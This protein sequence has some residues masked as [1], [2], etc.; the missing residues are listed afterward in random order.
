MLVLL[1]FGRTLNAADCT[2]SSTESCQITT[3]STITFA[4]PISQIRSESFAVYVD[5]AADGS[6]LN[7]EDLV[8]ANT[9]GIG[10][11]LRSDSN[12]ITLDNISDSGN[13][14][15]TIGLQLEAST[16]N[17]ITVD[18]NIAVIKS[19]SNE[20]FFNNGSNNNTFSMTGNLSNAESGSPGNNGTSIQFT[21]SDE[22]VFTLVG[23][24]IN[25]GNSS[26]ALSLENSDKNVFTITSSTLT[27]SGSSLPMFHIKAGSLNN[28]LTLHANLESSGDTARNFLIEGASNH[29]T[30][31]VNGSLT[32][33][34]D[35]GSNN[36]GING[37][38]NNR[39]TLNGA[40]SAT[41]DGSANINLVSAHSNVF[42]VTGALSTTGLD[43]VILTD[44][45]SNTLSLTGALTSSGVNSH[46]LD[47]TTS[48][49]NTLTV[50]GDLSA[51]NTGAA[52]IYLNGG[53]SNNITVTGDLVSSGASAYGL[54]FDNVNSSGIS[55]GQSINAGSSNLI[56]VRGTITTAAATSNAIHFINS[57]NNQLSLK[58]NIT[59]GAN[60]IYFDATS[61]NNT[62]DFGVDNVVLGT[63]YNDGS[64]NQLNFYYGASKSYMFT[65]AGDE[66]FILYDTAKPVLNGSVMSMG[67]AHLDNTMNQ[68]FE[69][70]NPLNQALAR[71]TRDYAYTNTPSDYWLHTYVGSTHRTNQTLHNIDQ[72]RRGLILGIK[73]NDIDGTHVDVV[74]NAENDEV[75][76][77]NGDENIKANSVLA[78][79]HLSN[80]IA[81][82]NGMLNGK[83]LLGFSENKANKL[84]L[85]NITGSE[86][87]TAA[88]ESYNFIVGADWLQNIFKSD[89]MKQD[90]RFGINLN[91]QYITSHE[92]SSYYKLRNNF[93]GQLE[94][95]VGYGMTMQPKNSNFSFDA[96][97]SLSKSQY[98]LGRDQDYRL[99]GVKVTHNA[100]LDNFYTSANTSMLYKFSEQFKLFTNLAYSD[101]SEEKINGYNLQVGIHG[102]F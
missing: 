55:I 11:D 35:A 40:L 29:N 100:E 61:D 88:Y 22:N 66:N 1:A 53:L 13:V 39:I 71:R 90:L 4:N 47:L 18:G 68:A 28:T 26:A 72:D 85:N 49:S 46:N 8:I 96:N 16:N 99:K 58:N 42:T 23:T 44:S 67:E 59:A 45:D 50:T 24:I 32:T 17:E 97:F 95:S 77:N 12:T 73:A 51:T 87:V 62:I 52:N 34:G 25:T 64:N 15:G 30:I 78:G 94:T 86:N 37:S 7:F 31:T 20:I 38:I 75:T 91:N 54:R 82:A 102:S 101:N 36:F 65:T 19:G 63:F 92:Y 41:G 56:N 48:D 5:A 84:V 74:L 60:A 6:I 57:D 98:F 70:L 89:V 76:Y 69:R 79:M 27:T 83:I 43:N 80:I 14:S 21:D 81:S 10:L 93:V 33:S 3:T 2:S 9:N